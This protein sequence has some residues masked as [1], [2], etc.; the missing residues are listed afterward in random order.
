MRTIEEAQELFQQLQNQAREKLTPINGVYYIDK[1]F[2]KSVC[3]KDYKAVCLHAVI[4]KQAEY[5]DDGAGLMIW[6]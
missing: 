1:R 6:I 4:S 3:G 5:M 2:I